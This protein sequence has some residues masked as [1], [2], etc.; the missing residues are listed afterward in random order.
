MKQLK[1]KIKNKNNLPKKATVIV[2]IILNAKMLIFM[3]MI[4]IKLS[5]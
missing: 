4:R 3:S 2:L 5:F 1:F